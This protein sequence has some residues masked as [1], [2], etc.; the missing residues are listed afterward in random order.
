MKKRLIGGIL[1]AMFIYI[2]LT[3]PHILYMFTYKTIHFVNTSGDIV[4]YVDA[5]GFPYPMISLILQAISAAI[6]G[7]IL[8]NKLHK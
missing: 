4:S 5:V 8:A 6:L 7:T 2:L 1:Y 3:L